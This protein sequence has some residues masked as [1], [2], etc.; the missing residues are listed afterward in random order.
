MVVAGERRRN[1]AY[2]ECPNS[3]VRYL[4]ETSRHHTSDVRAWRVRVEVT[5]AV[6][7]TSACPT[8]VVSTSADSTGRARGDPPRRDRPGLPSLG[9]AAGQ[10]RDA[11]ADRG[12]SA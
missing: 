3:P 9:S 2:V 11:P 12:R 7:F 8:G 4:S 10:G 5:C 6:L 1:D